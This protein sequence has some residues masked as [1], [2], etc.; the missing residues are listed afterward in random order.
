MG[1]RVYPT[2]ENQYFRY[3][4]SCIVNDYER[5]GETYWR[6][7]HQIPGVFICEKHETYLLNSSVVCKY[8]NSQYL[9]RLV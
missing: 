1:S 3:C 2:L 8:T 6:L 9:K 4:P 5:Y 7:N